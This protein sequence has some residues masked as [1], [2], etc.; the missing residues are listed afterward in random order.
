RKS[1]E[2]ASRHQ[3]FGNKLRKE[4]TPGQAGSGVNP[5]TRQKGEQLA[6]EE[7]ALLKKLQELEKEMQ[8]A[9]RDLAGA[10]RD[11]AAKIRKA[12]GEMQ[13]D[14]LARN[15]GLSSQWIRSG[16]G[17]YSAMREAITTQGLNNLR[18]KLREAEAAGLK[19][20]NGEKGLQQALEQAENL[21]RQ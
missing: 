18:D 20:K 12:L 10:D 4:F 1:E 16:R 21:R 13:Q 3:E 17:Y 7:D 6:E 14:E 11:A 5:M 2:L 8:S 19:G 9:A 15:M